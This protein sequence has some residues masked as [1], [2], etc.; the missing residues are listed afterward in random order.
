M[1]VSRW[2]EMASRALRDPHR[3]DREHRIPH[4]RSAERA[5]DGLTAR[6]DPG[7]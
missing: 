2:V 4:A 1:N 7:D 6:A 5:A 3:P